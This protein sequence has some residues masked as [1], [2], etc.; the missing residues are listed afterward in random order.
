[1]GII[2][3]IIP[4]V[5]KLKKP[6]IVAVF[7]V[8]HILIA[9]NFYLMSKDTIHGDN[10]AENISVQPRYKI[11]R[12]PEGDL[13]REYNAV[14][15]IS[16][17]FAQIYF[18]ARGAVSSPRDYTLASN[19]PWGRPSRYTPLVH[20][21]CHYT[22]CRLDYGYAAFLHIVIQLMLL[23]ASLA[24]AFKKLNIKRHIALA[25]LLINVCLFLT[26]VGLSWFERGQLSLFVAL[27]YLWLLLGMIERNPWY[28]LIS[29]VFAFIKWTSFPF[30]FVA[31]AVWILT[32]KNMKEFRSNILL[33]GIIPVVIA[34]LFL[35]HIKEGIFFLK[36]LYN[37]EMF[38]TP[39][40][41]T[42]LRLFPKYACKLL[43]F[44]LVIPGYWVA[45]RSRDKIYFLI[46]YLAGS[47][48]LLALYPTVSSDYVAP[49]LFGF[50]PALI[51]WE[52][53]G[54]EPGGA[55]ADGKKNSLSRYLI[56]REYL[57]RSIVYFF[58]A[59]L[60]AVSCFKPFAVYWGISP[61][62]LIALYAASAILIMAGAFR[63]TGGSK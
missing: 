38:A 23:Y 63:L 25:I 21:V 37:Q 16:A 15:R 24:Y 42:L 4:F 31:A 22:L 10:S 28:L 13:A 27:A 35:F 2:L 54:K 49:C 46:P 30:I 7:I 20:A 59:F 48:I 5:K 43:P 56:S 61:I 39:S 1:V 11:L 44:I 36:G 52:G 57:P 3:K 51:Y 45:Q 29:A 9:F 8:C 18:P 33:A 50:I 26:P 32:S 47:G 34:L 40:G 17:D 53:T 62:F 12:I 55:D 6:L 41:I 14:N 58:F 60:L 19:D